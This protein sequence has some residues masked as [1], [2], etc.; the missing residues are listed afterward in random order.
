M[1]F[2]KNKSYIIAEIGV[3]HDGLLSKAKKLI[4]LAKKCQVDAVKFQLF[5]HKNLYFS[6]PCN[7]SM[8]TNFFSIPYL[9]SNNK[10]IL[11]GE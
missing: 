1:N 8:P 6:L 4:D 2:V 7:K 10:C 5:D 3:N 9:I 11:P